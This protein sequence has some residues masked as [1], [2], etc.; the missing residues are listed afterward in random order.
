MSHLTPARAL[1]VA[2]AAALAMTLAGCGKT[3]ELARPAPLFGNPKNA[4]NAPSQT[5]GQDPTRPMNT[6]D[7][8]D[9]INNP[10]PSRTVPIQG[11]GP[12]PTAPGPQGLL[13]DPYA[14]PR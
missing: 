9:E 11:M 8:R 3:G 2:A 4:N 12:D 6:I 10:A 13:P 5:P 14:N 7:P 1:S